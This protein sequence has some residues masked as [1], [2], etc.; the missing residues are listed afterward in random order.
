M[1]VPLIGTSEL[2]SRKTQSITNSQVV[3]E[4]DKIN[5]NKM[6]RPSVRDDGVSMIVSV[7]II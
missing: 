7:A 1:S 4:F 6:K 2:R 5:L 3:N